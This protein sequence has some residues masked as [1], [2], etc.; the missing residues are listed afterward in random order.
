MHNSIRNIYS[1]LEKTKSLIIN[2]FNHLSTDNRVNLVL[3]LLNDTNYNG[4]DIISS[5]LGQIYKNISVKIVVAKDT[6]DSIRFNNLKDTFS[7]NKVDFEVVEV[8]YRIRSNGYPS[9]SIG[10][11]INT[12]VS[13]IPNNELILFC[14]SNE[15]LFS[16]HVSSLV[17]LFEEDSHLEIAE[18]EFIIKHEYNGEE[19]FNTHNFHI[20][21][22]KT[23]NAWLP[24]SHIMYKKTEKIDI[25]TSTLPYMDHSFNDLYY[26]NCRTLKSTHRATVICDIIYNDSVRYYTLPA[27]E[28]QLAMDSMDY[29]DRGNLLIKLESSY[30]IVY[31]PVMNSGSLLDSMSVSE[32][33]L[34]LA[35]LIKSLKLPKFVYVIFR[36]IW[37]CFNK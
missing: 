14:K 18:S 6:S 12:I 33:R 16:N 19:K 24:Y 22:A 35:N 32:R 2:K 1:N 37:R 13:S 23:K 30:N 36:K 20:P 26:V 17:R 10:S 27:F 9:R 11:I 28:L 15:F 34:F 3:M 8:D 5:I 29:N 4:E 7:Y 31:N 25:L 21:F